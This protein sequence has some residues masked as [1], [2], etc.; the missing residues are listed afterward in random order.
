LEAIL[1]TVYQP[2]ILGH[3]ASIAALPAETTL[4]NSCCDA[5]AQA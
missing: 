5:V 1:S 4:Y 3:R 2:H